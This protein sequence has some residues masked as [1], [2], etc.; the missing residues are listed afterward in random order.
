MLTQK[1]LKELLLYNPDTGLFIRKK[2]VSSNALRGAVAGGIV[3]GYVRIKIDRK[4]YSAHRLAFLYMVGYFPE[5]TV[6]HIN[7]VTNDNRWK[8][9]REV[10]RL[11]QTR[12][13]GMSKNNSSGVKVIYWGSRAGK[14]CV[15]MSVLGRRKTIGTFK[16]FYEAAYHRYAAEQ[17]LGFQDCDINSSAKQFIEKRTIL[18]H[19]VAM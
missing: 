19:W 1:R 6:D 5:T 12:N 9:L 11:C 8:N 7:R 3:H 4:V 10:T 13:C 18:D 15:G 14:W 2:R 17:C 16:D